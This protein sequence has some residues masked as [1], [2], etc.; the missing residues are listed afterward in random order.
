MVRS[1]LVVGL[2]VVLLGAAG[3]QSSAQVAGQVPVLAPGVHNQRFTRAGAP[4]VRYAISVPKS[5]AAGK[6][7][8]LVMALHFG[9]NPFGAGAGM[10]RVL[11]GPA[12]ADLGAVIVAPDSIA[13]AWSS[14]D[15]ERAVLDL[16]D[17][18][19]TAYRTDPKRVVVTGFSMGGAGVWFMAGRHPDRFSAAIPVAGRPPASAEGWRTPVFA[20]HS[21]DDDVVPFAPTETR[22]RELRGARVRAELVALSRIAHH[23]THRF[24][25]ALERAVPWLRETWK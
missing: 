24:A 16:L 23:E 21:R 22:I 9:G 10:L 20:V 11:V 6:P 12:F 2:A 18:I 3:G 19:Q 4:E 14:P 17:A 13:G 1:A 25:D 8:P 5:H 7:V 15:N